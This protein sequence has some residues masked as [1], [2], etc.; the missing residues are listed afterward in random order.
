MFAYIQYSAV[1]DIVKI[2][3]A[4]LYQFAFVG[5]NLKKMLISFWTFLK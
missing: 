4:F 2:A 3:T 5:K 1:H